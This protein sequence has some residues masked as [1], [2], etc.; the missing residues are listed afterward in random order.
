MS[1]PEALVDGH[2]ESVEN[3]GATSLESAEEVDEALGDGRYVVVVNSVCGCAANTLIPT[4]EATLADTD[5]TAYQVF[6]GVDDEATATARE[7]FGEYGPSSPAVAIFEDGDVSSYIAR[8][9]I[10]GDE[11]GGVEDLLD[12]AF[13]NLM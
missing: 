5:I 2:R 8:E 4:L 3:L 7:R 6:A 12:A 1:Y 10:L 13:D 11:Q 9:D